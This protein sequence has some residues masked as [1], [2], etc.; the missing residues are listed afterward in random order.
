[1]RSSKDDDDESCL[2][3][4]VWV[5]MVWVRYWRCVGGEEAL[6]LTEEEEEEEEVEE[7]GVGDCDDNEEEVDVEDEVLEEDGW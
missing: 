2:W 1:M 6:N 5:L 3:G 4:L 7:D